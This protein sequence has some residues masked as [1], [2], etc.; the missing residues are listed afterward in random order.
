MTHTH[1]T[2]PTRFV[3]AGGIRYAY[4]R[5][6]PPVGTPLLFMQHF[7]GG[8]DHWDPA[9]TD[10]FA[11][12]R[13]VIL[14]NNAGVAGSS[15]ETPGTI[16]AMA[17]HAADFVDA[18]AIADLDLLG[19][20]TG[21]GTLAAFLHLF[22]APSAASQAA[23]RAFWHRRHLRR[24]DADRPSSPQ[25]MA[26]RSAAIADWRELRGE[27]YAELASIAAPTLIVNGS[28][29]VMVRPSTRSCSSSTSPTPS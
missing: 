27:R 12:D 6:G 22:F 5:F 18:L 8:L 3:Q 25:T 19:F 14:F 10:G 20:S 13:P 11:R 23:G 7:R 28:D 2:A 9:V 29:D 15:G 4:R 16:E 17:R 21:E 1:A 26:A 24:A